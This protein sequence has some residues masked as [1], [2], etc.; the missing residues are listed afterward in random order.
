MT[1]VLDIDYYSDV[2]CVWAYI[3]QAR[4]NELQIRFGEQLRIRYRF[5]E[6][7][8]S[9]HNKVHR[10]WADRGGMNAYADHVTSMGKTWEHV[11]IGEQTWRSNPPT[12]SASAHLFIKAAQLLA[13]DGKLCPSEKSAKIDNV[14]CTPL[15]EF[16]WQLRLAFF[17]DAEDISSRPV[18]DKIAKEVGFDVEAIH[19]K[20]DSGLAI[21]AIFEDLQD[22]RAAHVPGSPSFLFNSGRQVLYGNV[23]YKIIEANIAELL[24][25]NTYDEDW[26]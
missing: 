12:S 11:A 26:C 19:G 25:S 10:G 7:F 6:T 8:A 13:E 15:E 17:R 24:E 22:A 2:L 20:I 18:Q 4:L 21:A 23:G 1:K 14:A 5:T 9:V 16:M 3:S